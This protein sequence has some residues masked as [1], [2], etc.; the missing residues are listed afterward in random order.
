MEIKSILLDQLEKSHHTSGW[1]VSLNKALEGLTEEQSNWK[2]TDGNH[3]IGALVAH[4]IF[5]NERTLSGLKGNK[6][7][8]GDVNNDETFRAFSAKE[9][10]QAVKKLHQIEAQLEQAVQ[11]AT[12]AQLVEWGPM[13]ANISMHNAYHTGQIVYIRK[14]NGWWDESQGVK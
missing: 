11:K 5:W 2:S 4:L 10:D 7:P 6:A 14:R 3:S 1:H 12:E 13:I 8:S 9:W